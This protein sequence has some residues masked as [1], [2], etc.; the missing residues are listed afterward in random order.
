MLAGYN[1]NSFKSAKPKKSSQRTSKETSKQ[2]TE[3]SEHDRKQRNTDRP[4]M[5]IEESSNIQQNV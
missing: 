4:H 3:R 2:V 5:N 1:Q